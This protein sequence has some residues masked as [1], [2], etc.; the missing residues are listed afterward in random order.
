VISTYLDYMGWGANGWG[1]E[2]F[3]GFLMTLKISFWSYALAVLFG[4]L[5]TG[6]KLS[7]YKTLRGI[8][9]GYTTV[10]RSLPEILMV[11]IVY[12]TVAGLAERALVAIGFVE[13]G[14]QFN[15]FIAAVFA[16]AF[17]SGAFMTEVLRAGRLAVPDGQIEAAKAIGMSSTRIF[18]RVIF[19]QMMRHAVP[20]M[21]NL[22]LSITKDSAIISVLGA[23]SELLYTGYRAAASTKEYVFFY[24]LTALLFLLITL[25]SVALLHWLE[26]SLNKGYA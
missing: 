25:A 8:A 13:N 24:G 17:V 26:R 9:V 21:G 15:P 5:G 4:L 18:I 7:Q 22:W 20:G 12:F 6:A 10:V 19:P 2:F 3:F 1:D 16:L 14:F 11:L 23:F